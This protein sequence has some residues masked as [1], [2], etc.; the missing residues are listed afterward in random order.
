V[1]INLIEGVEDGPPQPVSKAA[2]KAR[3]SR[4]SCYLPDGFTNVAILTIEP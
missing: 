1:S 2:A 3:A 4:I